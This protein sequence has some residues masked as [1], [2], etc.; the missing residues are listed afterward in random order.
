MEIWKDIEW[1]D[2]KYLVSNLG[3]VKSLNYNNTKIQ[4]IRKITIWIKWYWYLWLWSWFWDKKTIKV[5]RLVAQTFIPN[6]ENKDEINHKNWIKTDNRVD[7]L[8]WCTR[9]E[10]QLHSYSTWLNKKR[11]WSENSKSKKIL[12]YNL[13]LI[14][15]K[16]WDSTMDIERE[17]WFYHWNISNCCRWKYKQSYWFIWKF[18][19]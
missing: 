2:W 16:E 4:K 11:Y 17:L 7:N 19:T 15:I 5:H 18:K 3:N 1:Y 8:E 9:S 13:D 6:P 12:Q 14:F 10:N